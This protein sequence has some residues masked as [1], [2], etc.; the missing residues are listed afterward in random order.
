MKE[1]APAAVNKEKN[2]LAAI[3]LGYILS[4]DTDSL[5]MHISP[6]LEEYMPQTVYE[7]VRKDTLIP[8]GDLISVQ[9]TV[10]DKDHPDRIRC[11]VRYSKL[12]LKVTFVFHEEKIEGLWL[13]YYNTK[14]R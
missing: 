4:G 11:Y 13:G 5:Y 3:C 8:L 14:E 2:E 12:G 9:D 10:A 1:E 7:K 6:R